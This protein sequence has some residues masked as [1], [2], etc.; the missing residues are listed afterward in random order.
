M[1]HYKRVQADREVTFTRPLHDCYACHDTGIVQ[2]SDGL[3]NEYLADY[4]HL[5]DGR[6][7]T[8]CDAALICHCTAAYPASGPDGQIQRGGFRESSGE[9]RRVHTD[10]G[11]RLVGAEFPKDVA[12]QLHKRRLESWKQTEAEMNR[13]R[14]ARANG[15]ASDVPWFIGVVR[16]HIQALAVANRDAVRAAD[17]RRLASIGE[18]LGIDPNEPPQIGTVDSRI[19]AA[20]VVERYQQLEDAGVLPP[21][22]DEM[23]P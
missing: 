13:S 19:A 20:R 7:L 6:R 17:N 21:A 15:D 23:Q 12:R 8:G 10:L 22:L 11:D 9:I 2:N 14:H 16:D 3:A 5:P 4:D 18:I 1:A